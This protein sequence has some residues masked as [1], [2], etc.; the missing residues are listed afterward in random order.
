MGL[1]TLRGRALAVV[2]PMRA[3]AAGGRRHDGQ[4]AVGSPATTSDR[5]DLPG[6]LPER[7]PDELD[8]GVAVNEPVGD[9]GAVES[10]DVGLLGPVSLRDARYHAVIMHAGS[11]IVKSGRGE[12]AQRGLRLVVGRGGVLAEP[13]RSPQPVYPSWLNA[14]SSC[15][16]KLLSPSG[17]QSSPRSAANLRMARFRSLAATLGGR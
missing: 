15:C 13:P 5:P 12:V 2:R 4:P 1:A 14:S 16:E 11:R 7:R 9:L 10:G 17:G 3:D 8:P 6:A